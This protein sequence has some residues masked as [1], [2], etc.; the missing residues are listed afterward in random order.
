MSTETQ[1]RTYKRAESAVFSKTKEGFGGLSNMAAGFP[2]RVNGAYIRTS[3][4]LY[5]ACRFPHLPDVQRLIICEASPMTAKMKSKPYRKDSMPDWDRVRVKIMR[6]CL[7]VKLAQN[8]SDF[9][10]LLLST[11]DRPIV[12]ESRKDDFWGA[13]VVSGDTDT[14]VGTNALGRL[15]MEL[16]EQVKHSNSD[17]LRRVEPLP[18][19]D[20]LL[21]GEPIA[22]VEAQRSKL[23]AS[24][25]TGDP[26]ATRAP[27]QPRPSTVVP[28]TERPMLFGTSVSQEKGKT[29]VEAFKPYPEYKESG[30]P[31][32]GQVPGHWEMRPAFGA[33]VP[34]HERNHGMKEKTVLSLSYGR[35][36]V[37][38][39][40]KLHGLVPESFET[41]QIVNPGDIVLRTTDLQNDHTSLRVGMVRDRGIITSAYLA[42]RVNAGV[43]PDFGFQFL[44]V[45]DT[46]KAI[47]GYGSG[48]RQNLDF[49][50]FKRMPVA[51]PP[52]AEQAAMVRFLDR[53]NGRLER[54][55]RAKRKVIALLNEQKQAIIHR[56]VTRGLDSSVP[57]KPSGLSWLGDIPQHWR[58]VR[59]LALFSHRVEEGIPGLP[60]LQVS[61]RSGITA[62]E[63]DQFGRPKRLIADHTKYKLVRKRDLAYNTMRMWQG[64][65]GVSATDGLVSP[66]Y[67]VLTPRAGVNPDFYEFTFRTTA[68]MQEVN[69][70][71][72]GIVS[73]R[74]RLYWESFK[75]M[76]NVF[77]PAEEQEAICLSIR[78]QTATPN[79]AIRRLEREIELLREYRTRLVAEVVTGKLDVREAA[80]RLPEEAAPDILEDDTDPIIDPETADEEAVV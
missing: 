2:L 19:A 15:L 16:R 56:A 45:W 18:L 51:I 75:Q 40:E 80:A 35:I 33:F 65:V 78:D 48:L 9:S 12:E 70:Y 60:V 62:E 36:I 23:S 50:H 30:L 28:G 64:A 77:L 1:I 42:L 69:R 32:L 63:F 31:W 37:K 17:Q 6:W 55:I 61:L 4:A 73:D 3:E 27:Y 46:S 53:A 41:Y 14:L 68:Y 21:F 49:S 5:Q 76:P 25:V 20:F 66:A 59:N 11:S 10:R 47:Y 26:T 58:I 71:S 72:T 79:I 67:V 74:N 13:K 24:S 39:A 43:S 34:N 29:L 8:W 52:P 22:V 44:N 57:L 54:A 38:P 7:R